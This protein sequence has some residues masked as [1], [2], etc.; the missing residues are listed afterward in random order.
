MESEVAFE[1]KSKL[2]KLILTTRSYWKIITEIKHPTIK[3]KQKLVMQTLVNPAIIKR[4]SKD[5]AV[6][7]YYHKLGDKFLCAVVKHENG[8]GFL[9]TAY[10]TEKIKKGDIIWTK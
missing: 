1:I 3:G 6:Y 9:I 7:L 2:G 4:S 5:S 8:T 10:F